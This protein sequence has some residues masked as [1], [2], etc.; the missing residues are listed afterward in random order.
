MVDECRLITFRGTSD[1]FVFQI[2]LDVDHDYAIKTFEL[3]RRDQNIKAGETKTYAY[4]VDSY[5]KYEGTFIPNTAAFSSQL[6]GGDLIN[7]MGIVFG[8]VKSE[9]IGAK[10]HLVHD[11]SVGHAPIIDEK[12]FESIIKI[13]PDGTSVTM[14]D[15]PQIE[16]IWLNGKI[17]PKTDALML[18]IARGNH[19]FIPGPREPRFWLLLLGIVGILVGGGWKF[20]D[21]WTSDREPTSRK[22][23]DQ[24]A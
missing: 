24:A 20:Y 5:W 15:A 16:Y 18:A 21:F 14:Q 7:E 3:K 17:V 22:P 9:P 23:K 6:Q 12:K 19:K 1:H 11:P 2:S 13:I 10:Y 8:Q 4:N